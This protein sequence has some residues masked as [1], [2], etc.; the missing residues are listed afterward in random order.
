MNRK[1]LEDWMVNTH[2]KGWMFMK[3]A[4]SLV[5]KAKFRK[6]MIAKSSTTYVDIYKR[7][8]HEVLGVVEDHCPGI[9][10]RK[11]IR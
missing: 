6:I 8:C 9:A 2:T 4:V 10:A 11:Q 7:R 3:Q 5:G 1:E